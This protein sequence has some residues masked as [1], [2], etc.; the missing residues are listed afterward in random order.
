MTSVPSRSIGSPNTRLTL[1]VSRTRASR[2]ST[3]MGVSLLHR[4]DAHHPRD[5]EAVGA[6]AEGG[7]PRRRAQRQL[8]VAVLRELL[9]D[10]SRL[11]LVGGAVAHAETDLAG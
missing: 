5:A 11:V 1:A 6:H 7:R 9:E 2:A 4:V 3:S 10:A 8:D